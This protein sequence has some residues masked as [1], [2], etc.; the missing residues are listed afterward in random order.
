MNILL[1]IFNLTVNESVAISECAK[2]AKLRDRVE[3]LG[4]G[5]L[6]EFIVWYSCS[7]SRLCLV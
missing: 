5:V 7:V 3:G 6:L 4:L 2:F 1:V